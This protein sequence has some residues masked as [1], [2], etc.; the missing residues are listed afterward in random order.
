MST[1]NN[2]QKNSRDED[3]GLF[4]NTNRRNFVKSTAAL[5][6]GYWVAGGTQLKAS[7]SKME[8]V[9]FGCIGIGGKGSSDSAD[10]NR[11]G[12]VIAACDVDEDRLADA[13][14]KFPGVTKY[15]DYRTMLDEMGDKIDAVTVSTPDHTHAVAALAA[16]R[17]GKHCFCQKPLTHSIEEARM[18]G[19]VA[20]K[21]EVV[22]QMGNQGTANSN[23][24]LSAA[25]IRAGVVGQVK[26]VHVWTNRPV[27]PQSNNL[28]VRT[29]PAAELNAEQKAEWMRKK[30]AVHWKEWIGPAEARDY[31]PE[32]HPFKWRGFWAFGTGALG[33]MACHTLNMS[34][35]A[36]DLKFPTSV[37]ATNPAHDNICYPKSS[38]ILFEFPEYNGR[39]ALKMFWYDGGDRPPAE[40]L[41]DLPRNDKGKQYNSAA[42]I[43]G[44]KGKFYS[45]GDYGGIARTTGVIVDGKFTSQRRIYRGR[46]GDE[47]AKFK[48]MAY[49]VSPGH[50]EEFVNGINGNGVPVSNFPEYAGPLTETILLGNLAV[51]SGKKVE[52]DAKNMIA[53]DADQAVQNMIRHDYKNG[54]SIHEK[55]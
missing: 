13:S 23:L 45:P 8:Q 48:E 14:K 35:M 28:Q 25:M 52:W 7:T 27:W 40:L 9:Q 10:A 1:E 22:T 4:K 41:K 38:T 44:D 16:M 43:V 54:Y 34:Y 31:S 26:E 29:E 46:G 20:K 55:G 32:I 39:P 51:W 24:R 12:K 21:N 2:D 3:R 42:L 17:K 53:K 36:L 6:V 47:F 11:L 50:F 5:G 33:D 49:P 15:Y 30:K 37:V 19:D 18:M